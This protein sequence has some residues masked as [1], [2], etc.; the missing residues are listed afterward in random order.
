[1]KNRIVLILPYFGKFPDFFPFWL[2]SCVY[3]QQIDFLIITD[4]ICFDVSS[5]KNIFKLDMSFNDCR[6][7]I[8]EKLERKILLK[9][10]Y[11]LCDYRPL[12]GKIFEDYIR[13]YDFWGYCDCDMVLGDVS[14]FIT[15][16]ILNS[17]RFIGD[18][19]HLHIQKV[20]DQFLPK[21]LDSTFNKDG[22]NF[23]DA[24]ALPKNCTL[25]ELPYGVPAAYYKL[26]PQWYY[27]FF[28]PTHRFYDS[29]SNE[30]ACFIDTYNFYEELGSKYL[31]SMYACDEWKDSLWKRTSYLERKKDVAYIYKNKKLYRCYLD[32]SSGQVK[33]T[34]LL[35][36]HFYKR[37]FHIKTKNTQDYIITPNFINDLP[38]VVDEKFLRRMWGGVILVMLERNYKKVE[39][40]FHRLLKKMH[41]NS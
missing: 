6:I 37:Q 1:M 3:N 26:F 5:C 22:L 19:G 20:D 24:L 41:I 21:V 15:D 16:E 31:S 11:K 29:V 2:Q 28:T 14:K 38:D 35:Y 4:N 17:Y 25:D 36:A 13:G 12:Y 33:M 23:W 9:R 34:E 32:V 39:D 30:H 8:E 18:L 7:L 40:K 10:P 27:S